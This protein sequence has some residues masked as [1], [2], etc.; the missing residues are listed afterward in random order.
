[1][2]STK[3]LSTTPVTSTLSSSTATGVLPHRSCVR[4]TCRMSSVKYDKH[5][6]CLN[7]RD[8]QCS[9]DVRC[10]ECRAWSS[11]VMLRVFKA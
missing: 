10:D 1:M 5:T 11:E 2:D 8:V 4:C 3:D 9:L 7:C 6:L